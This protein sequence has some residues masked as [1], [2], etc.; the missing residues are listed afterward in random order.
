M[1]AVQEPTLNATSLE[2]MLAGVGVAVMS[3]G[4]VFVWFFDPTRAGFFPACWLYSTTGFACPGC[5]LTRGFH[6]LFHGDVAAALGFNALLP[7]FLVL[8]GFFYL[9][10][11][12]VAAKGKAF[13]RWS[14]SL[15]AIWGLLIL[16]LV[17][18]V[19]RNIPAYPFNLLFPN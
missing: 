14:V 4:A 18:G 19:I 8:I 15:P 17:F 11:A 5:G 2:R 12:Y 7:L 1:Q 3:L 13:P 10:M 9:T 16:L 6:A